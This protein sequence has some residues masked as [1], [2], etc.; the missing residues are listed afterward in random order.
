METVIRGQI[1]DDITAFPVLFL[2]YIFFS[3]YIYIYI[4][5][6]I[7]GKME[8]FGK[9]DKMIKVSVEVNKSNTYNG[10]SCNISFFIS[11]RTS[12]D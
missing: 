3:P 10:F 7:Y 4:Y 8:D 11:R 2:I 1:L 12:T 5:I 6:H 9:S